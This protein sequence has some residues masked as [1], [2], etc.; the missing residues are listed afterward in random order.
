MNII[1]KN[2]IL[3]AVIVHLSGN[4]SS[5]EASPPLD[6]SQTIRAR[7]QS[8]T[9]VISYR[10]RNRVSQIYM[11]S[12]NKKQFS[13][14]TLDDLNAKIK[15]M[16]IQKIDWIKC[17]TSRADKTLFCLQLDLLMNTDQPAHFGR[18]V[19]LSRDG[20]IK[21]DECLTQESGIFPQ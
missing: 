17:P 1:L 4:S 21:Y 19:Q 6:T 11:I 5:L 16:Q 15:A 10:T 13:A 20:A 12:V 14:P 9:V 3:A 2:F 7:C 8:D 18:T